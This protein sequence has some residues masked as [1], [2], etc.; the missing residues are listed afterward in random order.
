MLP[1]LKILFCWFMTRKISLAFSSWWH[2]KFL[3]N[4]IFISIQVKSKQEMRKQKKNKKKGVLKM[5]ALNFFLPI[6]SRSTT[7]PVSK[8][9][10]RKKE[11]KKCL[12]S[13]SN[14]L[15]HFQLSKKS[16]F[17][18]KNGII[19]SENRY[20]SLYINVSCIFFRLAFKFGNILTRDLMCQRISL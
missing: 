8:R 7:H 13:L 1:S 16:Y 5:K 2:T 20:Y 3:D 15:N 6:A 14:E 18:F 9:K 10:K 12:S 11:D 4:L 19:M 17:I